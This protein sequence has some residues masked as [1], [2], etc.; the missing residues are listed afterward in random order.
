MSKKTIVYNKR[1]LNKSCY[2][3]VVIGMMFILFFDNETGILI[4]STLRK[5]WKLKNLRIK[6]SWK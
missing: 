1:L 3:K 2:I 5:G 4:M 6:N